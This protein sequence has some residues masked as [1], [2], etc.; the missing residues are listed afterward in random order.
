MATLIPNDPF[1]GSRL[2]VKRAKQHISELDREITAFR[3]L[4]PYRL[5]VEG[6]GNPPTRHALVK[7]IREPM[8][9]S[10]PL[11]IGDAIHNLRSALDHVICDAIRLRGGTIDQN[12]QFP[13]PKG[14]NLEG[15]IEHRGI[16]QAGPEVVEIVR[17]LKPNKAG[18][19][20][21][22][23]IHDLDIDDKHKLL[24]PVAS[25]IGI[26]ALRLVG[27]QGGIMNLLNIRTDMRDGASVYM[28]PPL[29]NFELG[30]EFDFAFEIE[31]FRARDPQSFGPIEII[32]VLPKLIEL[33]T[34]TEDVVERIVGAC[35]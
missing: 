18:N 11:L 20:D 30:Q 34:L 26:P 33:T 15:A 31:L 35:T 19:P 14:D 6:D 17:G 1:R 16:D 12:T 13:M 2:K 5:V 8:P 32:P 3:K 27:V 25:T 4:R 7:R 29:A 28:G 21:L 23:L 9:D 24:L 10:V 22:R